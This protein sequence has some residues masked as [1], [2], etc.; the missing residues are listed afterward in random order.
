MPP[1]QRNVYYL[2]GTLGTVNPTVN[3][4]I[5]AVRYEVFKRYVKQKLIKNNVNPQSSSQQLWTL[6]IGPIAGQSVLRS[7]VTRLSVRPSVTL[8]DCHDTRMT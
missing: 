1:V 2:I 5:Y 8:V 7:N 6:V 3:P 4:L